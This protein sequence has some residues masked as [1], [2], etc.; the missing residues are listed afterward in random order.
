[1]LDID[2]LYSV[3]GLPQVYWIQFEVIRREHE[4]SRRGGGEEEGRT[5]ILAINYQATNITI[6]HN[7]LPPPTSPSLLPPHGVSTYL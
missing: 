2:L 5:L 6:W 7:T 4:G 1:M 3:L